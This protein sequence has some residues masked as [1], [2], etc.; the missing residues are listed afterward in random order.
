MYNRW[1]KAY[2]SE[3]D[4][5]FQK[6]NNYVPA[7]GDRLYLPSQRRECKIISVQNDQ[8]VH[9]QWNDD[10]DFS[11]VQLP[12]DPHYKVCKRPLKNIEVTNRWAKEI[13]DLLT[14]TTR[15]KK[16]T[17][18]LKK[19]FADFDRQFA[20]VIYNSLNKEYSGV[21]R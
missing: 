18:Y 7:V 5:Y 11:I 19:N 20:S 8:C 10:S 17:I 14:Q 12:D 2:S 13:F 16:S 6:E 15:H 1:L 4:T 21:Y 9:V 3:Y